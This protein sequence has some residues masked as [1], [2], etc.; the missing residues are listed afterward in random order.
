MGIFKSMQTIAPEGRLYVVVGILA[1][2]QGRFLIQQRP[3]GK[4][5]EGQWEFPGGK[6]EA[7]ETPADA[8]IRELQEELGIA[9]TQFSPLMQLGFD[10]DHA[11][12]WLD[13]FLVTEFEGS[14][15]SREGQSL[16]WLGTE[17]IRKLALLEAVYPIL[18]ELA[19]I[20]HEG[21]PV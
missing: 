5:C 2:G 1:D 12:V 9:I 20:F 15:E 18:D 10:Y 14:E 7:D 4:P 21:G 17:D 8:L 6:L 3:A 11:N 19:R 13:V 16:L